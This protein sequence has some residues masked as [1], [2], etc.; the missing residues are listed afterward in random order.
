MEDQAAYLIAQSAFLGNSAPLAQGEWA[1]LSHISQEDSIQTCPQT[2]VIEAVPQR[3]SLSPD[4][5]SS[6]LTS[7]RCGVVKAM[8]CPGVT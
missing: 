4:D 8:L 3:G 1:G 2:S 7:V 6:T 5:A